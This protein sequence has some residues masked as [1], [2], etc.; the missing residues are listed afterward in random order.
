MKTD[1]FTDIIRRKLESIR[2]EFTDKDWARMQDTLKNANLS[3]PPSANQPFSGSVWS[4]QSWLLA[5]ASISTVALIGFSIWQQREINQLRQTVGQ[6]HQQSVS[7]PASTSAN[8]GAHAPDRPG[9]ARIN[10]ATPSVQNQAATTTAN[11][12]EGQA[13]R[14]DTVYIT[15]YVEKP[16]SPRS[17]QRSDN[18]L[19]QRPETSAEQRY[20]SEKLI[21]SSTTTE[22]STTFNKTQQAESYD[23]SSTPSVANNKTN[24]SS[25]TNELTNP[26]AKDKG[27]ISP[28]KRE[29]APEQ[30]DSNPLH[31]SN[32]QRNLAVNNKTGNV[33]ENEATRTGRDNTSVS[34]ASNPTGNQME[35]PAS[36]VT[37]NEASTNYEL[38]ASLPL[39]IKSRNWDMALTQRARRMRPMQPTQPTV[40]NEQ[41]KEPAGSQPV[42][43]LAVRFRAGLGAE[44]ASRLWSAGVFTELVIGQHWTLGIGLNQA[45]FTNRFITDDDFNSRTQRNF[46]AE[47]ARPIDTWREIVN[48]D[49]RQVRFQIPLNLGY[50]V[51]INQSLSFLPTVGT[52]LDVSS[53][54]NVTYYCPKPQFPMPPQKYRYYEAIDVNKKPSVPLVN[55]FV[56]TS[57]IEW[58]SGHV[59]LQA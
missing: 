1:R 19:N 7:A 5:A 18:R 24:E 20:A 57:G 36:P 45:T 32:K 12:N 41:P 47:F 37:T 27:S 21:K 56:L 2:P 26:S 49:T 29:K 13:I 31:S 6:L 48:I 22:P 40:V 53:S 16:L 42:K 50:R 44:V 38:A 54:E 4:G 33:R 43:N 8:S 30:N 55:N 15:R 58:Q 11:R 39:S 3:T 59:V 28:N 17:E 34:Q 25:V 10:E 46:R 35:A 23:V 14:P 51:P 52:Y 9:V